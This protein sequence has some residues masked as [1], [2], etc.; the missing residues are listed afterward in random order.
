MFERPFSAYT[1]SYPHKTAYRALSPMTLDDLW[2]DENQKSLFLYLHVPFC[3]FRCGFCNLFTHAQPEKGLSTRY[4]AALKRQA[5]SVRD[6]IPDAQ[7]AQMAIGGGTP[8]YLNNEELVQLFQIITETMGGRPSDVPVSVEA[9]PATIDPEKLRLLKELG[10]DRLSVGVQSFNHKEAHAIGRPEK[11]DCVSRAMEALIEADF[12]TL[13]VDLIYGGEG[14]S[15]EDWLGS[16]D[17]T[18]AFSPQ[19]IFLYP[20]YVRQ[21][22]GLDRVGTMSDLPLREQDAWDQ[23]RLTAYREARD[24]LVAKGYRQ[25]S[26]RMFQLENHVVSKLD[27]KTDFGQSSIY[28][29]QDDGMVG[30]GSGARSYTSRVHYS[31]EYAVNSKAVLGIIHDFISRDAGQFSMA[32]YGIEL[33]EDDQRRRF[34]ILSLL[35]AEGLSRVEYQNR[36]DST[37]NDVLDDLPELLDLAKNELATIDAE[38]I[39]LTQAGIELSDAI[40][41]WLYSARVQTAMEEYLCR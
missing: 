40:G 35:M 24:R 5:E 18:M 3:E 22:T 13:N 39:Q 4:L 21:L 19:E 14:Q 26:L 37:G 36:F 32:D 34:V 17:Q 31:T 33:T 7:F 1:Y 38:R 8:T 20:L 6:A 12:E 15:I 27:G 9:S 2:R 16:V 30:L 23:K 25:K 29:C 11:P 28:R 41:P 10:V